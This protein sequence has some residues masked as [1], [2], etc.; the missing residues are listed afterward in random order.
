MRRIQPRLQ[1]HVRPGRQ[2]KPRAE[3]RLLRVVQDAPREA[4]EVAVWPADEP[5]D[6]REVHDV[7]PDVEGQREGVWFGGHF[8]GCVFGVGVCFCCSGLEKVL[9]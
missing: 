9:V 1:R 4:R 7:G 5:C 2:P 6:A 3:I 8:C